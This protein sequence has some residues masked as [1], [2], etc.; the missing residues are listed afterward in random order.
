MCPWSATA[1]ETSSLHAMRQ[2]LGVDVSYVGPLDNGHRPLFMMP[3]LSKVSVPLSR[4][5]F[6]TRLRQALDSAGLNPASYSGHS[7]RK[8]GAQSLFDAGVST[9]DIAC[10]GRWSKRSTSIRLYRTITPHMRAHW[11]RLAA[12]GSLSPPHTHRLRGLARL[13]PLTLVPACLRCPR[14]LFSC[15]YTQL[16]RPSTAMFSALL[17][18][19]FRP[20]V[21]FRFAE[22]YGMKGYSVA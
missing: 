17:A 15:T 3:S 11:A 13:T 19:R 22:F 7:M 20:F 12:A 18:S 21:R 16:S 14:D 10:A 2:Y 6:L 1:L 9:A 4:G 8:G 5:T